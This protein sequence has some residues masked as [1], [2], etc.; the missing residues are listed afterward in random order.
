M[1]IVK[2]LKD[3]AL[4]F[5]AKANL[6]FGKTHIKFSPGLIHYRGYPKI[7]INSNLKND[8]ECLKSCPVNV[9]ELQN[10]KLRVK[11]L[12]NCILCNACV[13][14]ADPKGA[15]EVNGS[16]TDF[17]FFIESWGQLSPKEILLK[18]LDTFDEK[19]DD[20]GDKLKKL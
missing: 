11:N 17:I 2:L 19:L 4:E 3:Q 20:F 18:A 10:K 15:V 12:L 14:I 7:K 6:G 8:S 5:E 9:F 13:D 1:P 16:D